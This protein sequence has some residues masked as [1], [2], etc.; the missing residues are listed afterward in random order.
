MANNGYD[1]LQKYEP[2]VHGLLLTDF[3]MPEMDGFELTAEIRRR[4][5]GGTHRLPIVALTADALPGTE[6]RCLDSG[7]D[8][9][10]TKPIDSKLLAETLERWL[11]AAA[12]LRRVPKPEAKPSG[13]D[14]T[15]DPL[16][17]NSVRLKESFGSFGPEARDFLA[18]FI[19]D[20]HG[21]AAAVTKAM[22]ASDWK[23]ARHHAH[24]L[25]G[26][27]LSLGAVR[28]GELAGE[29]Q[30]YLDQDD[31]ETASLFAGG[32]VTTVDELAGAVSPLLA[33]V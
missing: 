20:A 33:K 28:L 32:L 27:A 7:M 4:E 12:T 2:T 8:G 14:I 21:M 16:I 3:H 6:Q 15:I 19:A 25:K 26:A 10:L 30:D 29:V 18:G 1:A 11:P 17:F 23:D 31:P 13:S 9:Y 24:A 5:A 22:E